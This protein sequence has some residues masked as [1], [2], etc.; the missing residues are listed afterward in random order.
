MPGEGARR[1]S[2]DPPHGFSSVV[3][4]ICGIRPL[5]CGVENR[6]DAFLGIGTNSQASVEM[7]LGAARKSARATLTFDCLREIGATLHVAVQNALNDGGGFHRREIAETSELEE[8][9]RVP[10]QSPCIPCLRIC[11]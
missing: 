11:A 6:L 8:S 3:G 5:A 2:G 1:G 10:R 7:I 4:K 9:I